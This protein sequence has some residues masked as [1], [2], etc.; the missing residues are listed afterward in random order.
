M[1][2]VPFLF[3]P[4]S[5]RYL[6]QPFAHGL[7][8]GHLLSECYD[9]ELMPKLVVYPQRSHTGLPG[10]ASGGEF[11]GAVPVR[12]IYPQPPHFSQSCDQMVGVA[13][14]VIWDVLM[15]TTGLG[16]FRSDEFLNDFLRCSGAC[17]PPWHTGP[18]VSQ[19][20]SF[21]SFAPT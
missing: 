3:D 10:S 2:C 17:M 19:E 7:A 1:N 5:L 12:E 20:Y 14:N 13:A 4:L 18:Q 15:V 21:V 9:A 16:S 11:W 8:V 6:Y